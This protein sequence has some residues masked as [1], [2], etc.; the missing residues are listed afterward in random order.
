MKPIRLWPGV[1]F[2]VLLWFGWFGVPVAAP[3]A[4][5]YGL[6]AGVISPR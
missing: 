3:G 5:M 2:V 1:I 4:V 6:L